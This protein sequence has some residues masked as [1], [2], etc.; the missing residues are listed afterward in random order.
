MVSAII[1]AAGSGVRMGGTTRKQYITLSGKPLLEYALTVFAACEQ[2]VRT[3]LIVPEDD[4]DFCRSNFVSS[5]RITYIAGGERRQDSVYNGLQALENPGGIVV[6]HDGVRPF[7]RHD[8]LTACIR[9]AQM[10]GACILGIPAQDTLK[11]V[12]A[13]GE[14]DETLEREKIWHAQTPQAFQYDV[15]MKAHEHARSQNISGTDDAFLVECFGQKVKMI[16]GSHE[17]IKIT[18]PQ[19]LMAAEIFLQ[20]RENR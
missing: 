11:R 17:N 13:K 9:G 2:I 7:V 10:H 6:I 18:S 3:Y 4:I 19:D 1:V 8:Q 14:I 20:R 16:E 15:I 5:G 12:S